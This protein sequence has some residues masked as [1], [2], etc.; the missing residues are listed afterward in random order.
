MCSL[1]VYEEQFKN[2]IKD[3]EAQIGRNLL[4]LI[5]KK[6]IALYLG[7]VWC[8]CNWKIWV[9][10]QIYIILSIHG[11]KA[12]GKLVLIIFCGMLCTYTGFISFNDF[13]C[14]PFIRKKYE[15]CWMLVS[16][17][18]FEKFPLIIDFYLSQ[19]SLWRISISVFSF[20][21][22]TLP[23]RFYNER[24]LYTILRVYYFCGGWCIE[25]YT[26]EFHLLLLRK[27]HF[28]SGLV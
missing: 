28:L 16:N 21:S 2:K 24:S 10:L 20:F 5:E 11:F 15:L 1:Y 25:M 9:Y 26:G 4:V 14:T 18:L 8:V 27:F 23:L 12:V 3:I 7:Y 22:I 17:D 6:S 19:I 13:Y